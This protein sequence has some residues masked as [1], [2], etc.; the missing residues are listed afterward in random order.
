MKRAL[1]VVDTQ[2]DF[3]EGGL[4]AVAGGN[5]VAAGIREHV[6]DFRNRY[7]EIVF[8]ADWHKAPP[9]TNGG[10]FA[11]GNKEPDFVDSWPVHCVAG[12]TGS[13]LH[14]VFN[15]FDMATEHIFMKGHGQPDYSGFQG[16]NIFGDPLD[17]YL[18]A[19]EIEQV[20]VVG[21][22]GDYCVR[23]TALDAIKNGYVTTILPNLVA[24]V[25]G[26]EATF[27]VLEEVNAAQAK[28]VDSARKTW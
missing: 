16:R 4:L 13:L 22:A 21:I 3:C 8:T 7:S 27:N 17:E 10:H 1:I 26:V 25:G 11:L 9:D 6:E 5:A 20:V 14:P 2:I 28:G 24:S 15:D 12:T 18:K 23:A 19:K